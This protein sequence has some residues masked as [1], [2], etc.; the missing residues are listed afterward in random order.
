MN[1]TKNGVFSQNLIWSVNLLSRKIQTGGGTFFIFSKLTQNA[2][3][4]MSLAL[5]AC[6]SC[7]W[8]VFRTPKL[9]HFPYICC[10]YGLHD[11]I[12]SSLKA[13]NSRTAH[14]EIKVR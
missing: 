11:V 1:M 6:T 8:S 2:T 10:L 5:E 9:A 7:P 13:Y 12:M 14:F 3:N 4:Y